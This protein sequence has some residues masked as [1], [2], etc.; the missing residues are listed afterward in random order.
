L[1]LCGEKSA[2]LINAILMFAH[3]PQSHRGHE[4]NCHESELQ[5]FNFKDNFFNLLTQNNI[6]P[7]KL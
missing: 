2:L 1:C 6:E 7:K 5:K 4:A 3:S